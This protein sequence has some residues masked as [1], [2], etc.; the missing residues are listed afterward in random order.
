MSTSGFH[1]VS[2][3]PLPAVDLLANMPL[4]QG[5]GAMLFDSFRVLLFVVLSVG[6]AV[7][8]WHSFRRRRANIELV[9]GLRRT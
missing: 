5:C 4:P 2:D 8:L 1:A 6:L 3:L 7:M 9:H